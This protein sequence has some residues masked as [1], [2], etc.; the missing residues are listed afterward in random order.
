MFKLFIALLIHVVGWMTR[1]GY[2]FMFFVV[3]TINTEPRL[4]IYIVVNVGKPRFH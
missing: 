4:E 3:Y 2:T 1:S